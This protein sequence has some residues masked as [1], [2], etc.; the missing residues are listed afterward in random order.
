MNGRSSR[1]A[2]ATNMIEYTLSNEKNHYW[3]G[4]ATMGMGGSS[5]SSSSTSR[6]DLLDR[7]KLKITGRQANPRVEPPIEAIPALNLLQITENEYTELMD[8]F[9]Q[10]FNFYGNETVRTRQ[11]LDVAW[12]YMAVSVYIH[13]WAKGNVTDREGNIIFRDRDNKV[14][15]V[16][17][18]DARFVPLLANVFRNVDAASIEA[19]KN[20]PKNYHQQLLYLDTTLF[21]FIGLLRRNTNVDIS[22]FLDVLFTYDLNKQELS[23]Q[24]AQNR[25]AKGTSRF[26]YFVNSKLFE[27]LQ[28]APHYFKPLKQSPDEIY[29]D[30]ET[31]LELDFPLNG[32]ITIE[33][34]GMHE[35]HFTETLQ[36]GPIHNFKSFALRETGWTRVGFMALEGWEAHMDNMI[37]LMALPKVHEFAEEYLRFTDKVEYFRSNIIAL[38]R[39]LRDGE[40]QPNV[41]DAARKATLTLIGLENEMRKVIDKRYF[42]TFLLT[43]SQPEYVEAIQLNRQYLRAKARLE[44]L[45]AQ[46]PEGELKK[47]MQPVGGVKEIDKVLADLETER[48]RKK[49]YTEKEKKGEIRDVDRPT[50]EKFMNDL[51]KRIITLKRVI[52]DA[53]KIIE[54]MNE[55]KL[56]QEQ[57][58]R[59]RVELNKFVL[60]KLPLVGL[61]RK[62]ETIE[63]RYDQAK[64]EYAMSKAATESSSTSGQSSAP[65]S[66]ESLEEGEVRDS[67]EGS[68]PQ[69]K[70]HHRRHSV[71]DKTPSDDDGKPKKGRYT[72]Y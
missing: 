5:T 23:S 18:N 51:D 58:P 63:D 52:E 4:I 54:R 29:I 37:E 22:Q 42:E 60:S 24:V 7:V 15:L 2:Q 39:Q 49:K 30:D 28:H 44:E 32:R 21:H 8:E 19:F 38:Q 12:H 71:R 59:Y 26:E 55:I 20:Q 41:V 35:G 16:E 62:L 25:Q 56:I 6:E 17:Q 11:Q 64:R 47:L 68:R 65:D 27:K 53:P 1:V 3:G 69:A 13:H 48:A 31:G 43:A 67:S 40:I 46:N 70:T 45:I 57:L 34:D 14:A 36:H 9:A 61:Q 33:S 50:H 10:L 66:D 72:P